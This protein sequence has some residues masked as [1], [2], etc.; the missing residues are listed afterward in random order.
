M[1]LSLAL[2][3]VFASAGVAGARPTDVAGADLYKYAASDTVVSTTTTHFKIWYTTT[4]TNAIPSTTDADSNGVPDYVD[5]V[6]ALYESVLSFYLGRGFLQP[7]SDAAQS[8][9][10]GDGRFDVYL[11][12]FAGKAD[13]AFVREACSGGTCTGYMAQE[14]DFAGYSYPSAT[15]GN[16]VLASHEF[17][18]AVQAAYSV[19]QDSV[20]AEGTAVWAEVQFDPGNAFDL[21][22]FTGGYLSMADHS[23]DRPGT[24]PVPAFSYGMSVFFQFLSE[25]ITPDLIRI[26]WEDLK[27]GAR[28][29]AQQTWLPGLVA[30]LPRE[31]ST[32]FADTFVTFATWNLFTKN[33]ADPKR[34]YADGTNYAGVVMQN[35]TLPYEDDALRVFYAS[36]QVLAFDPAGRSQLSVAVL[37]AAGLG[38]DSLAPLRVVIAP[39]KTGIIGTLSTRPASD[40]SMAVGIGDATQMLVALAQTNTSGDSVRGILCIG[41]PDEVAACKAKNGAAPDMGAMMPMSGHGC[42]IAGAPRAGGSALLL[43][44]LAAVLML[45]RRAAR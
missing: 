43:L 11:L 27:P 45:R 39:V 28:G 34:A 37:P 29:V 23:I 14:N 5:Q 20:V 40:D 18:H 17:F 2:G 16:R 12:D 35:A 31:Y 9:N 32:T 33:R 1:R 8:N 22:G 4:G 13:G 41:S 44:A 3:L 10:G 38:V 25:K 24:G 21:A 19:D 26:L 42:A 7:L 15:V 36:E 6:G 30:L